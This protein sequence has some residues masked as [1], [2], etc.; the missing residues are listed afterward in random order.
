LAGLSASSLGFLRSGETTAYLN[1]E[2]KVPQIKDRLTRVEMSTE[3]Q[4]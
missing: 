1:V 2:G 3:K 4:S